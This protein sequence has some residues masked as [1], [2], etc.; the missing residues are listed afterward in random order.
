MASL[1]LQPPTQFDFK[2][3]DEWPRWKRRFEQFRLASG[4]PDES[5]D[6]QISTLLYCMGEEA[7]DILRS[8]NIT[9]DERKVYDSVINKFDQFFKVRK[10]VIFE[11]AKF[12]RRC[13]GD[14]ES[15]EQFITSLY[16]LVEDCDYGELKDQ[17][18]RDR[19]VV[20]IRDRA[21]SE[22]LQM[23]ADLTLEKAKIQVRQREAVHE[24]S[25]ILKHPAE[26]KIIA[27]VHHGPLSTTPRRPRHPG[28]K[29][30]FNRNVS[31]TPN[32][33]TRCGKGPH[34]RQNCPA[35]DA[36]CHNCK[37]KGHFNAQCL[38]KRVAG[39]TITAQEEA[40]G[41][42]IGDTDPAYL[43]TV[44]GPDNKCWSL[45]LSINQHL[46]HFKV[47]TGAEV[48]AITRSTFNQ[49]QSVTL[50]KPKKT[51]RGPDRKPLSI[52]G[53]ITVTLSHQ[54]KESRQTVYVI[55]DLEHNLL[56]L[57]AIKALQILAFLQ[58]VIQE[59]QEVTQQYPKLFSGLGTLQGDFHIRLKPDAKPFALHTSRN[60]PLPLR[61]KVK[62]EL[63]RMESLGVIS[64]V[65]EPT[66]WCAGMVVVPKRDG[67]VRICVDLKPLNTNVLREVHPLPKVDDTLAQLSGARVFSKL[68][69]NSGFWQ[70]PLAEDS[71]HMTTFITPFGRFCFNKMPFGIS[72]APEHFQK[73]MSE[74]LEGQPGV[75]CLLDDI[76]I[77]GNTQEEHDQRLQTTLKRLQN[78]G[79]TLNRDK[80]QFNQKSL[81]FLG[82]VVSAEGVTADPSKV[83]AILNMKQPSTVTEIRRFMGMVN[84]LGKFTPV[85]AECSQPLRELL[86]K[87][88][89]WTWGP[90]QAKA[91]QDIKEALTKPQVLALYNPEADTKISADA[92]AYGLGAVLLQKTQDQTWRAVAYASRSLTET[93]MRYAQIEK[94]ALATTWAC[95]RFTSY[96]LGK[97]IAIETDHKPLVPL[98]STKHLDA[99]PPRVLRF[100]LRLMRF[101]YTITHVAGKELYTAD[102]LSRAPLNYTTD[103]DGQATRT[104]QLISTVSLQLPAS[105]DCLEMYR[106]AQKDDPLLQ[107]VIQY[108]RDGWPPTHSV[109]GELKQYWKVRQDITTCDDLILYQ[110]RLVV[111]ENLRSRTLTMPKYTRDIRV[112]NDADFVPIHLFG[113]QE[114]PRR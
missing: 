76:I 67:S 30:T 70:I 92:S 53:T 43:N 103:D 25:Q 100:R 9:E 111:P 14:T 51:L 82:H 48:T 5:N 59:P 40:I 90:S 56:G 107:Q 77:Y 23:D 7:E 101:N 52:L 22:K 93:E 78:A 85:I 105:P 38:S 8:T 12:N 37:K 96:I 32:K 75:L 74:I 108:C 84:Q 34:S 4:L 58:E 64:K 89:T 11:R 73:R 28:P 20:G 69:A 10:N 24:Q 106:K 39:L 47:D 26:D 60:V 79:V 33:C 63:E 21:L 29:Q 114:S 16:N 42:T 61:K 54:G 109:K 19:I 36:V 110:N 13:Q 97:H 83:D 94:E 66:P 68:D 87:N 113:G 91:F 50:E 44:G 57:P 35:R 65:D 104:E 95:E 86:V 2:N 45:P 62:A 1:R 41:E 102:T 6:R 27:R 81:K 88:R 15:A 72:S 18:I 99:I 55:E 31:T 98:L 112:S 49:I 3:L 17:M 71:R 46:T 80:C